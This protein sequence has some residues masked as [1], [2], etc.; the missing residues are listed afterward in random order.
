MLRVIKISSVIQK[1][2]SVMFST[3]TFI[4]INSVIK[5]CKAKIFLE[6]LK[7]LKEQCKIN[8]KLLQYLLDVLKIHILVLKSETQRQMNKD[9]KKEIFLVSCKCDFSY[10]ALRNT[11][12]INHSYWLSFMIVAFFCHL[13]KITQ[14]SILFLHKYGHSFLELSLVDTF[15]KAERHQIQGMTLICRFLIFIF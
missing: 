2:S 6:I 10:L 15:K 7:Q 9:I 14:I 4:T 8:N 5:D 11:A 12:Y 1:N 3:G 13:K